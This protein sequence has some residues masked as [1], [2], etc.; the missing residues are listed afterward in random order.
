MLRRVPRPAG[1][2]L[3]SL[4]FPGLGLLV[5]G[6]RRAGLAVAG[7]AAAVIV[8]LL[9]WYRIGLRSAVAAAAVSPT[10]L[11]F[12]IIA[13]VSA[14]AVRVV[15][16]LAA[17]RAAAQRSPAPPLTTGLALIVV[18]TAICVPHVLV[19]RYASE[20]LDLLD[21]V[22]ADVPATVAMPGPEPGLDLADQMAAS[23]ATST[24]H[25]SDRLTRLGLGSDAGVDR[26]GVRTDTIIVVSI[27]VET[28][29]A[30]VFSIPRNWEGIPF[31]NGS[32]AADAYPDGYPGLANAIYGLGVERRDLFPG[33]GDPGATAI[34]QA[35][36]QLL[37]IPIQYH[38][39]VGMPAV[40]ETIDLFGGLDL[41]V[42]ERID[43][44]I[45]PIEAGGPPLTIE[46]RPGKHHF[47]GL[48]T[49]AY[50]RSRIES[51]DY[52]RMA[53]QRCVIGAMIDQVDSFEVLA[54]HDELAKILAEHVTTDVPIDELPSLLDIAQRMDPATITSINFVPPDYPAG[55]APTALVRQ[56]VRRVLDPER[57]ASPA[58]RSE[59]PGPPP[60]GGPEQLDPAWRVC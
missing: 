16:S 39:R 25:G 31:P 5:T 21:T 58:G 52:N 26:V 4:L 9:L 44:G 22:F 55:R 54:N 47:D 48:T 41:V 29:D 18:M 59:Q 30:A 46:T 8:G 42:T 49:L 11:W 24:W 43:D 27:D 37:G 6:A 13:S 23:P 34:K 40:V 10:W 3:A 36:A 38:V 56:E 14:M 20:Q 12:L 60:S 45:G 50:V 19:V 51:S 2:L 33:A 1:A 17:L 53:R 28:G 7:A 32:P 35:M 57:A 15:A